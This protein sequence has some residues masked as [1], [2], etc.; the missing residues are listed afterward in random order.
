[1][2]MVLPIAAMRVEDRDGA[3]PQRLAPDFTMNWLQ[4]LEIS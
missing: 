3:P 1:M 2:L 4:V